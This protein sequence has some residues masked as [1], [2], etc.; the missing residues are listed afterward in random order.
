MPL[1]VAADRL[2]GCPHPR[3]DAAL[4]PL[5]W[6]CVEHWQM[7]PPPT[8]QAIWWALRDTGLQ[9]P[10]LALAERLAMSFWE[11]HPI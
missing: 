7:L 11:E 1:S 4:P 8:R 10:V 6:A 2:H 5:V 3:C 9:S